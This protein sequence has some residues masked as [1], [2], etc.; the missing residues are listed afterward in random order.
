M[1]CCLLKGK[2]SSEQATTPSNTAVVHARYLQRAA[3]VI[4]VGAVGK[5]EVI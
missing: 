5:N 4:P 1:A 3:E 2:R